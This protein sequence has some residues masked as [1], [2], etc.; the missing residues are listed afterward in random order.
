MATITPTTT[1]G[2]AITYA[3]ASAGGDTV[4]FG[5]ATR[6]I[7]VIRNAS[8]SPITVTLA[9]VI[10]CSQ[11]FVHNQVVTCPVGDTDIDPQANVISLTPATY[12][13]VNL[14]YSATASITVGAISS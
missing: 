7:I 2:S 12:G 1:S 10:A 9:G 4:A 14:T 13:Q 3:A 11:G 5:A 6:P 8:A